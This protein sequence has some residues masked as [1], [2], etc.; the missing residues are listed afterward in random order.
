VFKDLAKEAI[1]QGWRIEK[2]GHHI[3][4]IPPDKTK[5]LVLSSGS[6]S[7]VRA[8]KNHISLLRKSGFRG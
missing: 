1:R 8:L 7:D 6:P 5:P 3:M 2:T 4:W